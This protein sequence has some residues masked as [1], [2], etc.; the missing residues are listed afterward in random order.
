MKFK[1][2]EYPYG[3][4]IGL[5]QDVVWFIQGTD[6]NKTWYNYVWSNDN[7]SPSIILET[8]EPYL[9]SYPPIS[10]YLSVKKANEAFDKI[11]DYY[12]KQLTEKPVGIL[13]EIEI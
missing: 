7:C 2:V 8:N 12:R 13:R 3:K 5:D 6:D 9:R 4:E 11:I 10:A 1:L